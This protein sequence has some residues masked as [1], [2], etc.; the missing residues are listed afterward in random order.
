MIDDRDNYQ[1]KSIVNKHS[2]DKKVPTVQQA[3]KR[4]GNFIISIYKDGHCF[5]CTIT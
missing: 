3:N 5:N 2:S 1:S 4:A